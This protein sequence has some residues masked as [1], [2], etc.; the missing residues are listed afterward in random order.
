MV[1]PSRRWIEPTAIERSTNWPKEFLLPK[2][3]G[4]DEGE[5]RSMTQRR[6]VSH[7]NSF[8]SSSATRL[9]VRSHRPPIFRH[10]LRRSLLQF[11]PNRIANHLPLPPQTPVPEPQHLDSARSKPGVSFSIETSSLRSSVL[12][13]IEFN[14]EHSLQTKEIEDVGSIRMLTPELVSRKATVAE[15]TPQQ[16]L[17]PTV[18]FAESARDSREFWRSHA[19]TLGNFALASISKSRSPSPRPSPLGRGS[20][21]IAAVKGFTLQD[22]IQRRIEPPISGLPADSTKE[23]P[24]PKPERFRGKTC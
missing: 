23:S 18:I 8:E 7:G 17:S 15:P 1:N 16:F 12:P 20:N 4:Q 10:R 22:S 2:G 11:V 14:I 3:E 19:F 13:S 6:V 24:L 9:L 21:F 5:P